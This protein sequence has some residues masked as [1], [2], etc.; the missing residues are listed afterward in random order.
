MAD[1]A[2][3][4]LKGMSNWLDLRHIRVKPEQRKYTNNLIMSY[5]QANHPSVTAYTIH[6]DDKIIGYVLLIH[7][8]NP[9]QWIIERLTIDVNYQR[10]GYAYAVVD[11]LIDQIYEY[12]NSE[13][14]VVRYNPDNEAARQLA[15]K[16]KFEEQEKLIRDRN[17]AIL[18]FE[19]EEV[20]AEDE[21]EDADEDIDMDDEDET[22]E[23]TDEDGEDGEIDD[24]SESDDDTDDSDTD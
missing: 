20:E 19:F 8:D 4:E 17:V 1:V 18:E 24:S 7:A 9:A 16:L 22:A 10:Q 14:V 21:E 12:E 13:M 2:L 15:K 23:D 6:L 11:Q 5:L 3:K